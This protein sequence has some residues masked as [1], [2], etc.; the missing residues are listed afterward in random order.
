MV[1]CYWGAGEHVLTQPQ[2]HSEVTMGWCAMLFQ[3]QGQHLL[4]T[5]PYVIVLLLPYLCVNSTSWAPCLSIPPALQPS[6]LESIQLLLP[7]LLYMDCQ[8]LLGRNDKPSH[9]R[10][11]N[12]LSLI[13]ASP[14]N[15]KMF[16]VITFY[17]RCHN[18]YS[19]PEPLWLYTLVYPFSHSMW[20]SL[21]FP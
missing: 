14:R 7:P 19:T 3:D 12:S 1:G 16:L 2:L 6:Q 20:L 18:G 4:S 17:P 8:V 21:L 9:D 10:H 15:L 5:P 13:S 11:T